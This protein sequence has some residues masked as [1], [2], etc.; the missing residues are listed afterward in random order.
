MKMSASDVI[1]IVTSLAYA[2][3]AVFFVR[4]P[5]LMPIRYR[6]SRHISGFKTT[7]NS[8][9]LIGTE[10]NILQEMVLNFGH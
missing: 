9:V 8:G 2:I 7:P 3:I 5:I 10:R 1:K 4:C 6:S